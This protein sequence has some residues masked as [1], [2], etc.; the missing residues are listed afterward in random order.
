M[1]SSLVRLCH[2][3]GVACGQMDAQHPTDPADLPP[4][5]CYKCTSENAV[6]CNPQPTNSPLSSYAC[7]RPPGLFCLHFCAALTF[8][9]CLF[10]SLPRSWVLVFRVELHSPVLPA[11]CSV[12]KSWPPPTSD[13]TP[14]GL[15]LYMDH[16][17]H[18]IRVIS[19]SPS[20]CFFPLLFISVHL[21]A[22]FVPHIV[23]IPVVHLH[24]HLIPMSLDSVLTGISQHSLHHLFYFLTPHHVHYS[25]TTPFEGRE[26][27]TGICG[28]SITMLPTLHDCVYVCICA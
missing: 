2:L 12:S 1:F 17:C 16:G 6:I 11:P 5:S 22:F 18:I 20:L 21:T 7:V 28:I 15:L 4:F 19:L 3:P 23:F 25:Y 13:S 24:S 8:C 27:L 10:E 26:L 14:C 9:L